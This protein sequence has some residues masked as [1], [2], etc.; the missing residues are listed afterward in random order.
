[1]KEWIG[2][3]ANTAL[4][5]LAIWM[6]IHLWRRN[7]ALP[8]QMR[9]FAIFPI[10]QLFLFFTV[11][12][13]HMGVP[14]PLVIVLLI[15]GIVMCVAANLMFFSII[16]DII[17]KA[18]LETEHRYLQMQLSIQQEHPDKLAAQRQTMD[19]IHSDILNKVETIQE[20]L[21]SSQVE[22]ITSCIQTLYDPA[23][24]RNAGIVCPNSIMEALLLYKTEEAERK[25]ILID[26][27]VSCDNSGDISNVDLVCSLSNLFDNAIEACADQEGPGNVISIRMA[28]YGPYLAICFENPIYP[29]GAAT[30]KPERGLGLRI[31]R[32]IAEKYAGNLLVQS[33]DNLYRTE[34][35]LRVDT[36][37][38]ES[39]CSA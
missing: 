35:T 30:P 32:D 13:Y 3:T 36:Q 22:G 21:E 37:R 34:L 7:K 18:R 5:G 1:M 24:E 14:I 39:S 27:R 8:I 38:G 33:Q 4:G 16:K 12:V 29:P 23:K 19:L 15:F 11:A 17:Q 9:Q 6:L 31:L 20:M 28:P 10:S 2:I 25:G 26:M